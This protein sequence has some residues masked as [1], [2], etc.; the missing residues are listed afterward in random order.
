MHV[1]GYT[2][3]E[4]LAVVVILGLAAGLGIPPLARMASGN[5][6]ERACQ[7]MNAGDRRARQ[8]AL[9]NGLEVDLLAEGLRSRSAA[10]AHEAMI[11]S[12][13]VLTWSTLDGRQLQR[14]VI[15]HRGH[16]KDL[17]VEITIG[18]QQRKYL[19]SGISG[20]WAEQNA[21]P[22]ASPVQTP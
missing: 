12:G 22:L 2:L 8:L 1:R 10:I 6:L 17:L 5:P 4:L 13:G 14:L 7:T 11:A 20:E 9:G 15:D 18:Q 3:I 16:S 19:V 21:K